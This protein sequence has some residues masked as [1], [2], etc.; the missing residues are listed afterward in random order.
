MQIKFL[1]PRLTEFKPASQL[2]AGYDLRACVQHELHIAPG[3]TEKIPTGIAIHQ[4]NFIGEHEN[5]HVHFCALILPRSGLGC[6]GV[7]PRNAPGLIDADYQGEITICLHND[8]DDWFIVSPMDRVAQLVFMIAL[9]PDLEVVT[10]FSN[11]TERG[12]GGFG[13]TGVK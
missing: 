11:Q 10:E 5:I 8:S 7:K 3:A 13:S 6:K 1:D 4:G 2:A 9:H 12:E